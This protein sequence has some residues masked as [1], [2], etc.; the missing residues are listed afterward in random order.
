MF[1]IEK[2]SPATGCEAAARKAAE[3]MADSFIHGELPFVTLSFLFMRPGPRRRGRWPGA[4]KCGA[5]AAIRQAPVG[6]GE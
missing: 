3:R 1:G 4:G 2:G 5:P 6:G